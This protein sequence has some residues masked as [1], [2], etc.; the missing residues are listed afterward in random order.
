MTNPILDVNDFGQ[1]KEE[2]RAAL[3]EIRRR[4]V[5]GR[6]WRGDHTVWET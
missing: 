1:S 6:M 2:I 4:D 3:E 5:L